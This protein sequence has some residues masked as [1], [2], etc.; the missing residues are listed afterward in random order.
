MSPQARYGL[1]FLLGGLL[2]TTHL[3]HELLPVRPVLTRVA[4]PEG[5]MS[6]PKPAHRGYYRHTLEIPFRPEHAWLSIAAED[7]RLYVNGVEV[8]HNVYL[9]RVGTAYQ[10]KLS[11]KA[12][13]LTQGDVFPRGGG[14][15]VAKAAKR[16]WRMVHFYDLRPHLKQGRN[17]LAVYVQSERLNRLAV[18]GSVAGNGTGVEISGNPA[19]WRARTEPTTGN[20]Q[21]WFDPLTEDLDWQPAAASQ[22]PEDLPLYATADP[23]IWRQPFEAPTIVSSVPGEEQIF[24]TTVPAI[25][26]GQRAWIRVWSS[27]PYDLFIGEAWVGH[28]GGADRVEA[29]DISAFLRDEPRPLTLRMQRAAGSVE[30][31]AEE[32]PWLAVDGRIGSSTLS[33]ARGWS[34]LAGFHP[35]WLQGDGEWSEAQ[36]HE[37]TNASE[38]LRYRSPQGRTWTGLGSW[39]W[40]A[41]VLSL[42]LSAVAWALSRVAGRSL[43]WS[44][45]LLAPALSGILV[46][47]ALRFRFSESDTLLAF[48][49]PDMSWLRLATGPALLLLSFVWL[50]RPVAPRPG[51]LIPTLRDRLERVPPLLWL[52]LI[53]LL[54]LGLR[55]YALEFQP[56]HVDDYTSWDAARGILRSG[57]PEAASGI[58]YTRSPLFHYLLAGWLG[59]FGDTLASALSFSVLPG[60]GLIAAAYFLVAAITRRRLPALLAALVLA[61]DPWS[62]AMSNLIRFYQLMQF[63]AVLSVLY[64]LKGFIWREGKRAQNLFFVFATAGVLSQEIFATTFA[65]FLA[66]FLI[67]YRPFDWQQDRNVWVGFAAMMLVC[68]LDLRTFAILCITPHVA[69]STRSESLFL[70]HLVHI[71]GKEPTIVTPTLVDFFWMNNGENAF[72]S[73]LFFTGLI[74]WAKRG[75]RAML[76]LYAVVLVTI[77]IVAVMVVYMKSRYLY[78]VYPIFVVAAIMTADAVIRQIVQ[79]GFRGAASLEPAVR[80]RFAALVA[81]ILAFGW[82]VNGEFDKLGRSYSVYREIDYRRGMEYVAA[83]K[84]PE[85]KLMLARPQGGAVIFGGVDYYLMVQSPMF[86]ALYQREHGMVD[87]WSGGKL[88]WKVDQLRSVFLNRPR[89]WVIVDELRWPSMNPGVAAFLEDCCSV[90][91]EFFGGQV[92]LWDRAAG[93]FSTA[94]DQGGGADSF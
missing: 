46:L 39:V 91:A 28:A 25:V 19:D 17:V 30:A 56:P 42:A 62:L 22:P 45:W 43:V 3:S 23:D 66:A 7:Y 6:T 47:E 89:V 1:F 5:W 80:R 33:T 9:I 65:A 76:T 21:R 41:A 29:F 77:P 36:A 55:V 4:M 12:Q 81:G 87:R 2:L 83:H 92:L 64:F 15:S 40:M 84:R 10:D 20:G 93:R 68:W 48:L 61:L 50:T 75:D 90:E 16:E 11:A 71:F 24:R 14:A 18:Y 51:A 57:V 69:L 73:A 94:T 37:R 49:D 52:A 70:P 60:V 31:D 34:H 79:G 82:A 53:C 63:F 13:S 58:L 59:L 32:V 74:Y 67:C 54:G 72:W 85:D 35:D 88:A 44:C 8:G 78:G 27:W 86:D 26:S 38:P